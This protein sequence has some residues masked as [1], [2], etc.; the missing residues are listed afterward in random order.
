MSVQFFFFFL[1]FLFIEFS[2]YVN[3]LLPTIIP[4][5]GANRV[6]PQSRP[7]MRAGRKLFQLQGMMRTD[8]IPFAFR[9]LHPDYHIYEISNY[10]FLIS[11]DS[12][13]LE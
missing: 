13:V 1:A 3:D 6:R 4:A 2:Q 5:I 11:N 10:Q 8:P 9:M 7:A 12:Y